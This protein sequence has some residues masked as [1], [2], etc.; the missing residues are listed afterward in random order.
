[1]IDFKNL[2]TSLQNEILKQ[3]LKNDTLYLE[4]CIQNNKS[5]LDN[6][7]NGFYMEI[8][9]NFIK[10]S[11]NFGNGTLKD[12]IEYAKNNKNYDYFIKL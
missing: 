1:M 7:K 10:N 12:F 11:T 9:K 6:I 2:N 4:I 8:N 3:N 5:V